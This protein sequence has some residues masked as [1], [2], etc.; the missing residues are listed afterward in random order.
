MPAAGKGGPLQVPLVRANSS[1][2]GLDSR[3]DTIGEKTTTT[4]ITLSVL[5]P[6]ACDSVQGLD[7]R[8]GT[9]GEK[10]PATG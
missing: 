5:L 2:Q 4:A 7:G 1:V 9:T 10:T 3:L 8:V 6:A